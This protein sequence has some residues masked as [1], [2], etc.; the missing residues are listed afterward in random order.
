MHESHL[1]KYKN[2][3]FPIFCIG[4]AKPL[5]WL[6]LLV[7]SVS[8]PWAMTKAFIWKNEFVLI[9]IFHST[10]SIWKNVLVHILAFESLFEHVP[11]YFS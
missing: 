8:L 5:K 10:K 11:R 3:N 2:N 4:F 1:C 7:G 9:G 6:I